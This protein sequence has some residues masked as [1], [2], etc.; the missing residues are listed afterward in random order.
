M[1]IGANRKGFCWSGFSRPAAAAP[2]SNKSAR[3]LIF[4]FESS[5]AHGQPGG[6]PERFPAATGQRASLKPLSVPKQ[7]AADQGLIG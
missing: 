5:Q 3:V 4:I 2:P 7:I 1:V 6:T